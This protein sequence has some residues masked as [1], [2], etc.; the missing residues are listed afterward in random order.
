MLTKVGKKTE[1]NNQLII[2]FT[3]DII[4]KIYKNLESQYFK[5][6]NGHLKLFSVKYGFN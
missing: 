6:I 5:N 3:I 2:K 1:I 4:V